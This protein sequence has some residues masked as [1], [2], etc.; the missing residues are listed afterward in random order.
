MQSVNESKNY[1]RQ[2]LTSDN[3]MT[4]YHPSLECI[5]DK[6]DFESLLNCTCAVYTFDNLMMHI[7]ARFDIKETE[8]WLCTTSNPR[9]WKQSTMDLEMI[10]LDKIELKKIILDD[11]RTEKRF[12]GMI[13]LKMLL[14]SGTKM[15]NDFVYFHSNQFILYRRWEHS[16]II[17]TML[18]EIEKNLND[19][20]MCR[21]F[22]LVKLETLKLSYQI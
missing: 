21:N 4:T 19:W 8:R 18:Y 12:K 20:I 5:L 2:S 17:N 16:D 15:D 10:V 1:V 9:E 22:K 14:Q 11:I 13:T 6:L 7:D 3:F